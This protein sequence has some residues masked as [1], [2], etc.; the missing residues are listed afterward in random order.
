MT[1][2]IY[3]HADGELAK[4]PVCR[5]TAAGRAARPG[6]K[7]GHRARHPPTAPHAGNHRGPEP[8]P[9]PLDDGPMRVRCTTVLT[10]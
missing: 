5:W 7:C 4:L 1:N 10:I 2:W 3:V 8:S 9:G 6:H